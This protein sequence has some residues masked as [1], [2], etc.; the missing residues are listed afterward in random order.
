MV[1]LTHITEM[2]KSEESLE[3]AVELSSGVS[4]PDYGPV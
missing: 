2:Q 4:G 1:L 3:E